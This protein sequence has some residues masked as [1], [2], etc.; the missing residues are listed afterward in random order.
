MKKSKARGVLSV[1]SQW[2]QLPP[3][4]FIKPYLWA[5]ARKTAGTRRVFC[6]HKRSRKREVLGWRW[7]TA[8][9]SWASGSITFNILAAAPELQVG[10]SFPLVKKRSGVGYSKNKEVLSPAGVPETGTGLGQGCMLEKQNSL[11]SVPKSR[12]MDWGKTYCLP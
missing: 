11:C 10:R 1:P 9:A 2:L 8:G 12:E 6:T 3:E 5:C 7:V 4:H